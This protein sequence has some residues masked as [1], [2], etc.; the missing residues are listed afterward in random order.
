MVQAHGSRAELS[1]CSRTAD[2]TAPTSETLR[3]C[4]STV[5]CNSSVKLCSVKLLLCYH[6]Q[7]GRRLGH[8]NCLGCGGRTHPPRR[9][10]GVTK[11]GHRSQLCVQ[12]AA[13]STAGQLRTDA[14]RSKAQ[15]SQKD[16]GMAPP[17]PGNTQL[18]TIH[19]VNGTQNPGPHGTAARGGEP[20]PPA[21]P[22][23]LYKLLGADGKCEPNTAL[24]QGPWDSLTAKPGPWALE[25]TPPTVDQQ[26]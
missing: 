6:V 1:Q 15:S 8:T 23:L 11:S 18:H 13:A 14:V 20:A 26:Q 2:S 16:G 10:R 3:Q 7:I 22:P 24:A 5:L 25:G 4:Q 9:G 12:I 21:Q 17:T 19:P